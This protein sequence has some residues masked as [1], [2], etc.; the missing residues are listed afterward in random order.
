MLI[1]SLDTPDS[2]ARHPGQ[3]RAGAGA[4]GEFGD[5]DPVRAD[6]PHAGPPHRH[7]HQPG[8]GAPPCRAAVV[9]GPVRHLP[10]E[11]VVT[12]DRERHEHLG[13]QARQQQPADT[14]TGH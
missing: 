11:L 14:V 2:L 3:V 5:G 12:L 6:E 10:L 8:T 7:R 13:E 9:T 1:A 4:P